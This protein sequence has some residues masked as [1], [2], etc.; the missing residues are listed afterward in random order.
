MKIG[1]AGAGIM[2][3]LMS[4]YLVDAGLNV[5]LFDKS[6]S[7][8]SS[9]VAAGL[10]TPIAELEKS[11]VLIY[12]MGLAALLS[13][14]PA[15]L[16]R[17][18]NDIYFRSLGS[19]LVAH[20]QDS[21]EV[22]R[23]AAHL[24]AKLS[25]QSALTKLNQ[26]DVISLEPDLN[27]FDFG[28][29]LQHEG[30]IDNQHLMIDLERHLLNQGV[31]WHKN[32]TILS[33][34]SHTI[35]TAYQTHFFD[36]VIDT[37]G[38]NAKDLFKEL[39]GIR[40]ELIWLEALNVNI[41]RPVRFLHPRY[42]LYIVPR[43]HHIYII[44]ASEIEAEDYSPIS[45]QTILE[46]LTACYSVTTHFKEARLLKSLTQ[47][48]PVLPHHLPEIKVSDGFIAINGLYRHGFLIAPTLALEVMHLINHGTIAP[49]YP[50]LWKNAA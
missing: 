1:I 29:Y 24:S 43:P 32:T 19:L 27:K 12:Q 40:G 50:A 31:V 5:T 33:T 26:T 49:T 46:L 37:R 22:R 18:P 21:H 9:M 47:C 38:V 36:L 8:S 35:V 16:K 6:E 14:W 42:G 25:V 13:F 3:R 39:R 17:L 41:T 15:I 10:L 7:N 30:Q 2:G 45:V 34:A 4:F 44:G 11:D 20:P 48:R 28:Y 23:Y